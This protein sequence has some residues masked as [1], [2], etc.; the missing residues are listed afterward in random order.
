MADFHPYIDAAN[1]DENWRAQAAI[2]STRVPLKFD[3]KPI[4][5][6]AT[7]A[8]QENQL[9]LSWSSGSGRVQHRQVVRRSW[10]VAQGKQHICLSCP[11]CPPKRNQ[12][13][14]LFLVESGQSRRATTKSTKSAY[15]F[16][17]KMCSG[18]TAEEDNPAT[19]SAPLARS[20]RG[21]GHRRK[22]SR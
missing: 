20:R 11:A 12:R 14:R 3:F 9:E 4:G 17:C 8:L 1:F 21:R 16:L 5:F 15:E 10:F 13:K 7:V 6:V 18:I 2:G 22:A 19:G